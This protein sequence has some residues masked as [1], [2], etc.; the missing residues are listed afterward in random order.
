M[1]LERTEPFAGILIEYDIE[2][3]IKL[4][5]VEIPLVKD[6]AKV[7]FHQLQSDSWC[8]KLCARGIVA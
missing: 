7:I 1:V 8:W 4:G 2:K 3:D 5:K 6:K